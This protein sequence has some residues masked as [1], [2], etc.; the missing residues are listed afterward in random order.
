MLD[1][2][3][4]NQNPLERTTNAPAHVRTPSVMETSDH[5]RRRA[6]ARIAAFAA[7]GGS[8]AST[9]LGAMAL[10]APQ[11]P[12]TASPVGGG[13]PGRLVLRSAAQAG[14]PAKYGSGDPQRPG[15]CGEIASAVMRLDPELRIEG[16]DQPVPLRRLELMLGN[17]DLDVFFCLLKSEHR[18]TLMR[19]LPVPLYRVSH[20]LAMRTGD[21]PVPRNWDD[22]R[23]LAR[24]QPLLLAQGTKLAATLHD[25][26]IPFQESAR[27]DREALQMLV[28]N[29]VAAVYGQDLN[30]RQAA[31]HAGLE[32]QV[33]IGTQ[34]FEEET[35]YVVVSRQLPETA[36]ERL[37]DRLRQLGA[38]GELARLAERYR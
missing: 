9:G 11:P 12:A 35:Q 21:G 38:S 19:Y 37:T 34:V 15:L 3:Q 22:L 24:Q 28:R 23:A 29:R 30:L 4:K 8:A 1:T 36:V 27:S 7:L 26:D 32:G 13:A 10:A 5:N 33:R 17:G 18:Q 25:A 14:A 16:L 31:R 20:V 6:L 2:A